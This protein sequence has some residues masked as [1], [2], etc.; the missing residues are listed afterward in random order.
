VKWPPQGRHEC[1]AFV[2]FPAFP[3]YLVFPHLLSA[4]GCIGLYYGGGPVFAGNATMTADLE[5]TYS[6]T[7]SNPN[8]TVNLGAGEYCLVRTGAVRMPR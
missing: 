6:P 1:L 2:D 5:L 3:V 8:T 4:T 7:T